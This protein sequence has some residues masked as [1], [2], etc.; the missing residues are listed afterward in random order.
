[1]Q[2]GLKIFSAVIFV[3]ILIVAVLFYAN[4]ESETMVNIVIY[5]AYI[6]TAIAILC[7]LIL[8]L[9]LLFQYPK[10]L[11]KVG[12]SLLLVVVVFGIGYL[13]SSG[14][15]INLNIENQPS[16]QTL[17]LTDTGLIVTYILVA[18]S[19]ITIVGGSVKSIL[20]KKQ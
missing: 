3:L 12:L 7:T 13:L 10:K 15:P 2:K 8:P 9:P 20:D 16:E 5:F 11:K 18:V 17:K 14:D 4:P 19:I 1:M 6:L